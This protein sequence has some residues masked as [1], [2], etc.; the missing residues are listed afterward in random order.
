MT[1][2]RKTA[3]NRW[4]TRFCSFSRFVAHWE[5]LEKHVK[6]EKDRSRAGEQD[7]LSHE[8][9][10]CPGRAPEPL[11]DGWS[12]GRVVCEITKLKVG[13]SIP[14]GGKLFCWFL[15]AT[16]SIRKHPAT[17]VEVVKWIKQW[18]LDP[19]VVGSTPTPTKHLLLRSKTLEDHYFQSKREKKVSTLA[20]RC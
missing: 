9:V 14:P 7:E 1:C 19:E 18:K 2:A 15:P 11:K 4:K 3:K 16:W 13:G 12:R 17:H 6:G 20:Q 8:S 10:R 5:E